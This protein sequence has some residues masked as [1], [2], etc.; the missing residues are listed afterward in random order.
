MANKNALVS[1]IQVSPR[2][3]FPTARFLSED[4]VKDY[5]ARIKS[6]YKDN[7]KALNSLDV[8]SFDKSSG[9]PN[10]SNFWVV[11]KLSAMGVP[12]ASMAT[13]D[14]IAETNPDALKGHYE[15]S[16]DLVLRSPVD[17][18]YSTN[19]PLIKDLISQLKR[20]TKKRNVQYPVLI[21]SG[22]TPAE[23]QTDYGLIARLG[24]QTKVY[25]NVGELTH[26]NNGKKFNILDE[27]GVPIFT[28][29][30][31]RTFYAKSSGLSRLYLYGYL[32]LD[33]NND[34]LADSVSDGRVVVEIGEANA[35]K[36]IE[37]YTIKLQADKTRLDQEFETRYNLGKEKLTTG[38][39]Q[40]VNALKGTKSI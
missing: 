22:I 37:Q 18:S 20:I 1:G 4:E 7:P 6:E 40:A 30:G 13:L 27:R 15:D 9:E 16:I 25:F 14:R 24:D 26:S 21:S 23:G 8:L 3:V 36:L 17:Q 10:G 28:E 38:F 34:N 5:Q 32:Y 11:S 39:K 12:I 31:K 29:D 33:S 35:R 19:N 2:V